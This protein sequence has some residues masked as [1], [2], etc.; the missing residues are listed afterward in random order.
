MKM[1][2]MSPASLAFTYGITGANQVVSH[3]QTAGIFSIGNG[4]RL[5]KDGYMNQ[6]VC[7]GADYS[8]N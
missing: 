7:G 3:S 4:Y 8:L 1:N 6:M 5:I 2:F